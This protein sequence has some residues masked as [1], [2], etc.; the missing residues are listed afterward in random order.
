MAGHATGRP[1]ARNHNGRSRAGTHEGFVRHRQFFWAKIAATLCAVATLLYAWHDPVP[2]PNGGS[3]LGYAL[4]TLG[5]A[6]IIWLA[7]LGVRK[8]RYGDGVWSLKGWTSAHVWLGLALLVIGTLHTGFQLGWNVHTLAWA[9]MVLVIASGIF[10]VFA[11]ALLPRA[12]SRNRGETTEPM[13][14]AGIAALNR[15]LDAAAQPLPVAATALVRQSIDRSSITGSLHER[16][17]ARYPRCGNRAALLG[18]RAQAQS[19]VQ[20]QAQILAN[21]GSTA[22]GPVIALLEKKQAALVQARQHARIRGWLELWLYAHVPATFALLAA[23]AV[24]VLAVFFYW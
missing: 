21:G 13:M 15:Q 10:G 8:R 1:R 4:G 19:Q 6:L 16:L 22:L 23:L 14:L 18:L 20:A 5:A 3:P 9:L 2:R 17:T 24:H 7:L 12:L 11:Y